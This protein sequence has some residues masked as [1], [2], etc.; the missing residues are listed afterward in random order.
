MRA[1]AFQIVL[2][3]L[4]VGPIGIASV[5][6]YGWRPTLAAAALLVLTGLAV[7]AFRRGGRDAEQIFSQELGDPDPFNERHDPTDTTGEPR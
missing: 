7:R 2:G 4:I 5:S 3:A 1:K 6:S